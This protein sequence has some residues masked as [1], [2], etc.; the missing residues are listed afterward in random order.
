MGYFPKPHPLSLSITIHYLLSL[1]FSLSVALPLCECLF[2]RALV[3]FVRRTC[4]PS[5]RVHWYL[6]KRERVCVCRRFY[7]VSVEMRYKGECVCVWVCFSLADK[8]RPAASLL[9]T[10]VEEIPPRPLVLEFVKSA[11]LCNR[12]WPT[13]NKF[14]ILAPRA[15]Q[16]GLRRKAATF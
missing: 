11:K 10:L 16:P 3:S 4:M 6:R 12:F 5:G 1:S 14:W 9:S 13:K 8:E 7:N 2:F 15:I